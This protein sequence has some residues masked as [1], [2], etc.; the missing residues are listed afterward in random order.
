MKGFLKQKTG[1]ENTRFHPDKLKFRRKS[2]E[3]QEKDE[4]YELTYGIICGKDKS[5]H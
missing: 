5:L 4:H 2:G 1:M 3:S